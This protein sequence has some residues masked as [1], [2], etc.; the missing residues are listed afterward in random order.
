MANG[1]IV[2][3]S[4]SGKPDLAVGTGATTAERTLTWVTGG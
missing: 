3:W 2:N 4:Y 1:S